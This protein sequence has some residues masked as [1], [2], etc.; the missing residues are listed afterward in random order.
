MY[1]KGSNRLQEFGFQVGIAEVALGQ[2]D[3]RLGV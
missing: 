1:K 2:G 3:L